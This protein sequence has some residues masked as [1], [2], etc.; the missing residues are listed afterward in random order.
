MPQGEVTVT[1]VVAIPVEEAFTLFTERIDRWWVRP[2]GTETG[3]VVRFE[4]GRL[5]AVTSQGVEVLA[6]VATWDPPAVLELD[7]SGPHSRPGDRVTIEFQPEPEGTRVTVRHHRE[8]VRPEETIA[9]VLG[10]WWG[11]VLSRFVSRSPD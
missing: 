4:G 2:P 3:S 8:G 11:S 10:L 1:T 5:V 7:W 9:A 6:S